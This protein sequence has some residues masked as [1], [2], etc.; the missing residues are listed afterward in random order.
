MGRV[1][2]GLT[3]G[4]DGAAA[5]SRAAEG[6]KGTGAGQKYLL[7]ISVDAPAPGTTNQPHPPPPREAKRSASPD[8]RTHTHGGEERRGEQVKPN[9]ATVEV[10]VQLGRTHSIHRRGAG[11]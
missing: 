6:P 10:A 1:R 4:G 3:P 11:T 8:G 5:R 7:Q 2:S 9:G